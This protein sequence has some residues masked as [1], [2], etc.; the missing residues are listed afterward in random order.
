MERKVWA[1]NGADITINGGVNISTDRYEETEKFNKNNSDDTAI[2]TGTAANIDDSWDFDQNNSNVAVNYKGA[3]TIEGDLISAYDDKLVIK[4][5][6][7]SEIQTYSATSR[8][9]TSN[10]INTKGNAIAGNGGKLSIDLGDGGSWIGRADDYQ[11]AGGTSGEFSEQ[12]VHFF[13]PAF[14]SNIVHNGEVNLT[15]CEGSLWVWPDRGG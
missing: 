10:F 5:L 11:D 3:S 2:V 12:H 15:M 8:A 6:E 14:S 7:E 1:Y 13:K 4:P 9:N